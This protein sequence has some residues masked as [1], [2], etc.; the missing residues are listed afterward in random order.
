MLDTS[1]NVETDGV[2][3]TRGEISRPGRNFTLAKR[4]FDIVMSVALLPLLALFCLILLILNP[5]RNRG[6]LFYRQMRMGYQ[7]TPFQVVKFRSMVCA[8]EI[9]READGPL[10]T[11]R[12][13]SLGRFI[14]KTRID[15]LPQILNVLRGEMSLIGPRPDYIEH[16]TYFVE[17][18]PGYRQRH[19]MRPGISGLAQT[20]LGYAEGMDQTRAKVNADL[21]YIQTASFSTDTRIVIDTLRTVLGGFGR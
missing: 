2:F 14:R 7:C 11:S 21:E 10:E 13:T 16:A 5:L 1:Y 4:A 12:I 20:R 15:E 17:N 19:I 18:V 6:P 3:E 9:A 8:K